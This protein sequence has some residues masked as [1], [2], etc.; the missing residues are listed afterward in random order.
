MFA[1]EDRKYLKDPEYS[2][3][4]EKFFS[5]EL[6]SSYYADQNDIN[7]KRKN[8][9]M[10]FAVESVY[11][12]SN[13]DLLSTF[14]HINVDGKTIACTGSGG[15]EIFMSA[16]AGAKKII[17]V[18]G[19][20]YAEPFIRYKMAAIQALSHDE[21]K[22]YFVDNQNYFELSVFQKLFPFLDERSKVFWGTVFSE[23]SNPIDI[24]NRMMQMGNSGYECS[25][26][27]F[28]NKTFYNVLQDALNNKEFELDI[29]TAEFNDFPAAIE[30]KCDVILLSNIQQYV[31]RQDYVKVINKL[32]NNNLNPEGIIQLSYTFS[33]ANLNKPA[34]DLSELFKSLFTKMQNQISVVELKNKD[35]TFFLSKP[36]EN[37]FTDNEKQ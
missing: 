6:G 9:K 36:K 22:Q 19:N 12:F 21:F 13:E 14:K 37:A 5:K 30:D 10:N 26:R 3:A 31:N 2:M 24:R 15:D 35:K 33:K 17:H 7:R 29:K 20:L 8:V 23:I 25:K 28:S 16:V 27:I 4:L 32:Y 18:D 11:P 34:I 1:K